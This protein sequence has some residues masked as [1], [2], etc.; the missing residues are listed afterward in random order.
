[1]KDRFDEQFALLLNQVA[2]P[3]GLDRRLL[4]RLDREEL[5]LEAGAWYAPRSIGISR[6]SAVVAGI[7]ATAAALFVAV[8]LTSAPEDRYSEQYVLN[9]AIRLFEAAGDRSVAAGSD[10]TESAAFPFSRAVLPIQGMQ[11]RDT[12]EL[13]GMSG[14]VY[15]LPG[16][17]GIQAALFVV[18]S[19]SVE[20]L[21]SRPSLSPFSTAGCC[22]SAWNENGLVYVLVVKGDASAYRAY[23]NRP[24]GTVA[25]FWIDRQSSLKP[26]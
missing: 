21:G 8:L 24:S 26:A 22:A 14:A 6:R 15:E 3:E 12:D 4:E 20:S 10:E 2:V 5:R 25:S 16:S 23:L 9:E 11:R 1:M 19:D 17:D 7:L 13:L 18:R